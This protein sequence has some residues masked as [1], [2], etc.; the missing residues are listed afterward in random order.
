MGKK[1]KGR[2]IAVMNIDSFH[3]DK[4]KFFHQFVPDGGGWWGDSRREHEKI[5]RSLFRSSSLARQSGSP[6]KSLAE[7]RSQT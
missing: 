3:V 7:T 4:N 6:I 1:R 2:L 5:L